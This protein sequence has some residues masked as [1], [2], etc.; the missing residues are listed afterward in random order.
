MASE[1]AAD[2]CALMHDTTLPRWERADAKHHCQGLHPHSF[3][4]LDSAV[5]VLGGFLGAANHAVNNE[6]AIESTDP[7]Y[8]DYRQPGA[9][10]D[11]V[12]HAHSMQ[13]TDVAMRAISE[14]LGFSHSMIPKTGTDGMAP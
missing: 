4:E 7:S 5:N 12:H 1:P 11:A 6:M 10:P 8:G 3:N 13:H 14:M 9:D 2:Y